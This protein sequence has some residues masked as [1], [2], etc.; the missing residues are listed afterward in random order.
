[1][2]N[3]SN[4]VNV[5]QRY[6]DQLRSQNERFIRS[7]LYGQYN[8]GTVRY[9]NNFGGYGNQEQANQVI[10]RT[11]G[12]NIKFNYSNPDNSMGSNRVESLNNSIGNN[13]R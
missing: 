10:N 8:G 12:N 1:M 4:Q 2:Y 9:N 5:N 6:L 3:P 7:Q 11:I 13:S